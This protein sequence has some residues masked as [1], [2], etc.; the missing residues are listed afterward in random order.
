MPP[1]FDPVAPFYDSL[2]FI[3]YG[4]TLIRAKKAFIH[5]LPE[6]GKLLLIGGGTG[7]ILNDVLRSRKALFIDFIEPSKKMISLAVKKTG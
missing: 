6:K 5:C 1:S 4:N 7:N 3:V 2:A